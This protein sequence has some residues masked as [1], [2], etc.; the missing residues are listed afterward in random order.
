MARFVTIHHWDLYRRTG[1]RNISRIATVFN[2]EQCPRMRSGSYC[3][4]ISK[5]CNPIISNV[6]WRILNTFSKKNRNTYGPILTPASSPARAL[7]RRNPGNSEWRRGPSRRTWKAAAR[8]RRSTRAARGRGG[9]RRRSKPRSGNRA[10]EVKMP[11]SPRRKKCGA[12]L[13]RFRRC[14]WSRRPLLS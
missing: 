3:Y 14:Y 9:R 13:M 7:F 6:S 11:P 5:S 8:R 10:R 12:N 2:L 4:S 1:Q